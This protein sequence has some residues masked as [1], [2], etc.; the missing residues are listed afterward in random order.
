MVQGWHRGERSIQKKL[1]FDGPM[2]MAYTWID[3][4]MPEEH[5]VFHTTRLPFIP[6]TTLDDQGRPWSCIFAGESGQP[7]FVSSPH[8]ERLDMNV[9]VWPGDPFGENV[10]LFEKGKGKLLTAG[11]G[12]EFSTRRRNKFAGHIHDVRKHGDS[13]QIKMIVNQAIGNCPKYINIRDL[14]PHTDTHPTVEY[15]VPQVGEDERLPDELIAFVHA[16]DTVFIGSTYVASKEDVAKNP[17]HVGQN[18]RGGRP[19]FIRVRPSDGKTIV[20]PDFSGNRLLTSLGNIEVT[21]LASLTFVDFVTGDILYLTGEAHNLV[22]AEAREI[23]PRQNVLTLVTVTGYTFVRD[24]LPVRQRSGT[25]PERSPYSPPIHLLAEEREAGASEFLSSEVDV[26]LTAVQLAQRGPATFT[27]GTSSAN[28]SSRVPP[29]A[30]ASATAGQSESAPSMLWFAGGIGITPFLSML[31]AIV[32]L[33]GAQM[34]WDIV[35]ALSTREPEVLVPLVAD[36]L[37]SGQSKA[38]LRLRVDVFS[39]KPMPPL[40]SLPLHSNFHVSFSLHQGRVPQEY[41]NSLEDVGTKTA[42]VCGPEEFERGVVDMLRRKGYDKAV[43]RESF[44]Y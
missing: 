39:S 4:E 7:G 3:E 6:V 29:S 1:G 13:Y 34:M 40:P 32:E 31:R 28:S 36:A 12:I 38:K 43:V 16:A 15:H 9:K 22:G 42:Y 17:S 35:F 21:P 30:A 27:W 24:A 19:G 26:T 8:W 2:K 11:I 5:R 20:V 44:E 41:V 25:E 33:D 18:Q 37:G 23:M 10:K 14:I